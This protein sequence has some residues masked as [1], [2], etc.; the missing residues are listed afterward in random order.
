MGGVFTREEFFLFIVSFE[1]VE[2]PCKA[3]KYYTL[4]TIICNIQDYTI[5]ITSQKG[6]HST[7]RSYKK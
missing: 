3:L 2:T 7:N 5:K 1:G 6:M 4:R